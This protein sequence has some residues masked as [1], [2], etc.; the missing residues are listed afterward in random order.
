M[1]SYQKYLKYKNKYIAMKN[2]QHGG[3]MT[4]FYAL[5][6]SSDGYFLA[7]TGTKQIPSGAIFSIRNVENIGEYSMTNLKKD[8]NTLRMNINS[9]A[10]NHLQILG[11]FLF[12]SKDISDGIIF[13]F[14]IDNKNL[15]TP[16]IASWRKFADIKNITNLPEYITNLSNPGDIDQNELFIPALVQVKE[17]APAPALVQ[18]PVQDMTELEQVKNELKQ[19]REELEH[20]RAQVQAP[21]PAPVVRAPVQA[22]VPAPVVRAHVQAPV[23]AHPRLI[24]APININEIF[25]KFYGEYRRE[26]NYFGLFNLHP[27]NVTHH[28]GVDANLYT[29][30]IINNMHLEIRAYYIE[31]YN[32]NERQFTDYFNKNVSYLKT[33]IN[34][35][36]NPES[37]VRSLREY[38]LCVNK[39][40]EYIKK[41]EYIIFPL[42]KLDGSY[43]HRTSRNPNST[44]TIM[45]FY[46]YF[47]KKGGG[48]LMIC[49]ALNYMKMMGR[50]L[51]EVIVPVVEPSA[52][53]AYRAQGFEYVEKNTYKLNFDKFNAKCHERL[54]QPPHNTNQVYV[55]FE[56]KQNM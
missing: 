39:W 19:C 46:S 3:E 16:N 6:L 49:D 30:T 51:T 17:P 2:Y 44:F 53:G 29:I 40:I 27:Q 55:I 25:I 34:E 1:E 36:K 35:T 52:Q 5:I 4:T 54:D 15:I 11:W 45:S 56:N 9:G 37:L 24:E 13:V 22:P 10:I 28:D 26:T 12:N 8:I 38:E 14:K 18:A 42:G 47:L 7:R 20:I 50:E 33:K 23:Q 32:N 31:K 21:V 48:N 43:R 41:Y